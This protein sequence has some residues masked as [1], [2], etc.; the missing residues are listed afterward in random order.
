MKGGIVRG[1]N[2]VGKNWDDLWR[3]ESKTKQRIGLNSEE[4]GV[5]KT[6]SWYEHCYIYQ[7]LQIIWIAEECLKLS[8]K[9]VCYYFVI[10]CDNSLVVVLTV[11]TSN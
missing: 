10:V 5:T 1:G 6:H 4:S 2:K 8:R 3:Y 7:L 9:K 11:V